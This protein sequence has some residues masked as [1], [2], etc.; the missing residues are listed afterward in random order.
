V[1]VPFERRNSYSGMPSGVPEA[2]DA[3]HALA[4]TVVTGENQRLKP[5]PVSP[6]WAASLKPSPDTDRFPQTAP[7]L[8]VF[9]VPLPNP[10][11]REKALTSAQQGA[12]LSGA[13]VFRVPPNPESS[14]TSI[15]ERLPRK[16]CARKIAI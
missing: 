2:H 6:A 8:P 7:P 11:I 1:V 15:R 10:P 12:N 14:G 9:H 13:V 5:F 3:T 4:A 16:N